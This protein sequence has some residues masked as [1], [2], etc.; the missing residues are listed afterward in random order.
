VNE[1]GGVSTIDVSDAQIRRVARLLGLE[2]RAFHEESGTDAR[3]S[4]LK[5][6]TTFDVEACPGSGKTTLLVAKLAILAE[7]WRLPTQGICVLSHTNVARYQ[8]QSRLGS[9][10]VGLTLLSFPHFIG[11]IHAFVDEFLALPWLRSKGF[12]IGV[13]NSEIALTRRWNSLPVRTRKA[14]Q[15]AGHG[16]SVLSMRSSDF[17]VGE[18]RWGKGYLRH[19]AP[20]YT[21]I[22]EACRQSARDGYFCFDEMFVWADDLMDHV[23][24]IVRTLRGRFPLLFIDEAQD[25]SDQQSRILH[26]IFM[27]GDGPVIR[28]RF[29]DKNQAIYDFLSATASHTDMFPD[30]TAKKTLNNS[31]RF[32]PITAHLA[33]PLAVTSS[34]LTGLGPRMALSSGSKEGRHTIFLFEDASVERVLD[35][36]GGLLLQ[37][38]SAAEIRAGLFSAVG[39]VHRAE[40]AAHLPHHVGHYW[41]GYRPDLGG[42]ITRYNSFL[43]YFR[44]GREVAQAAG[45]TC[46]A[47]DKIAEAIFRLSSMCDHPQHWSSR[48]PS[49]HGL[50]QFASDLGAAGQDLEE[51]VMRFVARRE[52][53]LESEWNAYWRERIR[54]VGIAVAGGSLLPEATGFLEWEPSPDGAGES[55]NTLGNNN[56]RVQQGNRE[57]IIR[58]GSIHSVK[59]QTHDATLVLETFWQGKKGKHNLEMLLPWL[60]GEKVGAG[61][62]SDQQQMRMRVHYVALTRPRYLLCLAMKRSSFQSS[63]TLLSH[64]TARGWHVAAVG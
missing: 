1:R 28:Q 31:Y 20:T 64:M 56:Y 49:Y 15:D 32:G 48:Q 13:V 42:L 10:T 46:A 12:P 53:L 18:I 8:V 44:V 3:S 40:N 38:F 52:P 27:H 43:Q 35:A 14:L 39:L 47:A 58:I 62:A 9:T 34:A 60:V 21:A 16:K 51:F 17:T 11:T 2:E 61:S 30:E 26:R 33:G 29:G 5:T 19:D 37:T 41:P 23:P 59:G 63:Q 4:V 54:G 25:N 24:Q 45:E 22:C 50:F 6:M 7:H 55:I 57:V 36:Y